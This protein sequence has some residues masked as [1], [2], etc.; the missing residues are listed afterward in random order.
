VTR[1]RVTLVALPEL[2]ED[3]VRRACQMDD[4]IEV[5]PSI[6][7]LSGLRAVFARGEV[8]VVI[9]GI[10]NEKDAVQALE[11]L[12]LHPSAR[13]LMISARGGVAELWVLRP[14]CM[15]LGSL[16]PADIVKAVR[17]SH[18][19]TGTWSAFDGNRPNGVH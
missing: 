18:A 2:M 6:D 9:S 16:T 10:T 3:L 1:T 17:D 4:Q 8:D 15:V 19:Q 12:T 7:N 11:A 14:Q 13:L 5:G